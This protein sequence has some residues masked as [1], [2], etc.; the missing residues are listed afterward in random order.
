M[1]DII[2]GK[3]IFQSI[4]LS[5]DPHDLLEKLR[6]TDDFTLSTFGLPTS[7]LDAK[8]IQHELNK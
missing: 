1:L 2:L 7:L 6:V 8:V 4:H 5:L 3:S